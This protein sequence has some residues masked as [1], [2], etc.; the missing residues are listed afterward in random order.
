MNVIIL[1]MLSIPKTIWV[2]FRF[3]PFKQ[4]VKMPLAV[5]YDTSFIA[6]RGGVNFDCP[7]R[8]SMVRIGFHE[9]PAC[10]RKKTKV[11][12]D[13]TLEFGGEAHIGNGSNIF[14]AKCGRMSFGDDFKISASSSVLCYKEIKFGR[15]IQFSWDCLVMDSDTHSILDELGNTYNNDKP[16]LFGDNIWICCRCTILKGT[17]IPDNCVIGS[18]SLVSG[19]KF[20]ENTIIT[21]HPAKSIR[22]IGG[23]RL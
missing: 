8:R 19:D 6:V 12:V 14:V 17:V 2:N 4:A 3:L 22:K 16:I 23:W 13:G 18:A 20:D 10:Q 9:V 7:L 11:H 21:G 1:K 15:N 5:A